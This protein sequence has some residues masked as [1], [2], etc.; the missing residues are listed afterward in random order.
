[1]KQFHVYFTNATKKY[2]ACPLKERQHLI[3]K[4]DRNTTVY[5]NV[6]SCSLVHKEKMNNAK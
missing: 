4:A 2:A 3:R 1:M 6:T 5:W